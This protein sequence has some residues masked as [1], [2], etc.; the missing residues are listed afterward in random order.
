MTAFQ[1]RFARR[2]DAIARQYDY[3][4]RTVFVA[5]L[6][7]GRD[8]SIDLLEGTAIVVVGDEQYEFDVP[9]GEARASMSNGVVT[10]EVKR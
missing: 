9:E 3:E 10:V 8:G 6:G 4:D 2:E 5:D 1:E 7:P